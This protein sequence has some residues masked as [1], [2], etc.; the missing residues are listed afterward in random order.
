MGQA[1]VIPIYFLNKAK[2]KVKIY[3]STKKKKKNPASAE[4]AKFILPIGFKG[5]MAA[6]FMGL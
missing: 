1:K 5:L 6:C 3:L 2:Q 4:E